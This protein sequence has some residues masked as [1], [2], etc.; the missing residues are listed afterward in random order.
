MR[1]G[2]IVFALAINALPLA[3]ADDTF[4]YHTVRTDRGGILPWYAPDPA[5]AYDHNI[6]ILWSFWKTMRS[7][8]NGVPYYL[9]H[10]VWKE[11]EDDSRGLGGDQ[12]SMA[13]SSWYLLYGYLGDED[14]K[15]N[16]VQIATYW[17]AH[18]LSQP[19]DLWANLPYPYNTDLRSGIYDGDMV[20]GKGYLQPDKAANFGSELIRLFKITGNADYL[21]AA[22]RIADTLAAKVDVGDAKRSPLPFRVDART[23][24]VHEAD[25]NG[26][27]FRAEYTTDWAG[28]LQ[29][30]FDLSALRPEH[31]SQYMRAHDLVRDWMKSQPLK[32]NVWGPFFEDI[33]TWKPT[34]TEIN[35][36]TFA[37][38]IIAQ[39]EAWDRQWRSQA[40]AI[41]DWSFATFRNNEFRVYGVTPLNE[42]T[43]YQVPGNSH[44]ARH[45]SVELLYCEATGDCTTKPD[46]IRRLNWATYT[47]DADGKNRYPR[48]DIWLTDGYGDYV[49]HYLRAMAACP[50]LA[51]NDQNHLLRS[52]SVVQTIKY[53]DDAIVYTKFDP[54]SHERFKLG[55]WI[56]A[57]ADGDG[58]KAT[59]DPKTRVLEVWSIKRSVTIRRSEQ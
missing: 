59:W 21:S 36:D 32:S 7:D 58:V 57:V 34:N 55:A 8:T 37:A 12:I 54:V 5:I 18:G 20:A 9:E 52:S 49:R 33:E 56:P 22:A 15:A 16:M 13:L 27:H 48:D 43:A 1:I 14:I 2:A 23:G 19:T 3:R 29:L 39:R 46:A 26:E 10:Q 28:A 42:Q 38:Y 45:A 24:A 25:K 40:K 47:V 4:M 11:K 30:F 51:P 50:E 6:R 35:A 31:A 53:G 44:T 41:L 17:L